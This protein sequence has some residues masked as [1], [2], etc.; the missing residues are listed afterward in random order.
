VSAVEC[1]D[2][3]HYSDLY[4]PLPSVRSKR[5]GKE[6]LKSISLALNKDLQGKELRAVPLLLKKLKSQGL[7]QPIL[8]INTAEKIIG[9]LHSDSV[10]RRGNRLRLVASGVSQ[11]LKKYSG[12]VTND[13]VVELSVKVLWCWWC[14][15]PCVAYLV[16]LMY[17]SLH[18]GRL[19]R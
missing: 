19:H 7:K 9:E 10:Y 12:I 4:H 8:R 18:R 14:V 6:K 3:N 11:L 2:A 13:M 15:K 1:T 17:T 16:I 5:N